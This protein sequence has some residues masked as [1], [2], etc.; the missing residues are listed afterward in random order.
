MNTKNLNNDLK[1][2]AYEKQRRAAKCAATTTAP[3]PASGSGFK[4]VEVSSKWNAYVRRENTKMRQRVAELE[5][6]RL[7]RHER[8]EAEK[9]KLL[10]ELQFSIIQRTL[11]LQ[12]LEIPLRRLVDDAGASGGDAR[13]P[14][15][16][17]VPAWLL[18]DTPR[19]LKQDAKV[20][21]RVYDFV[22]QANVFRG[23]SFLEGND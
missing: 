19:D 17:S 23:Q 6:Q 4:A 21:M 20:T 1:K 11:P 2:L 3:T 16:E 18:T 12:D 7:E 13:R 10:S 5:R 22:R 9:N 14:V 8:L 15:Y